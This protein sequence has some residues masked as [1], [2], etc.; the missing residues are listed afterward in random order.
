MLKLFLV[1]SFVLLAMP[2]LAEPDDSDAWAS[3]HQPIWSVGGHAKYR[4][5]YQTWPADSLFRDVLG[6]TS[7][8]HFFETRL[9]LAA[10]RDRWDLQ[11]DYQF[12]AAHADTLQ[13]AERL[14]GSFLPSG[15]I[16]SD[17]RRWWNLTYAFG[18]GDRSAID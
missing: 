7:A 2:R 16:A 9:K 3:E 1:L 4:F 12:I 10:S 13:L 6:S 18:D 15:E 8:D 14:P 11:A 5:L 17:D